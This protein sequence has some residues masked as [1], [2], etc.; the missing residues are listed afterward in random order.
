MEEIH[1]NF[2]EIGSLSGIF[3]PF[4]E[5]TMDYKGI[6]KTGYVFQYWIRFNAFR[7]FTVLEFCEQ[8]FIIAIILCTNSLN[9]GQSNTWAIVNP[10]KSKLVNQSHSIGLFG[11]QGFSSINNK[12]TI[13]KV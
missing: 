3:Y 7:S 2:I 8:V 4:D 6:H 11:I 5:I 1:N 12:A 9:V 10:H 13:L